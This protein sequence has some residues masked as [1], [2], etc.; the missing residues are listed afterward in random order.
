MKCPPNLPAEEA[1][2]QALA[3]HGLEDEQALPSLDPVV[4]IAARMFGM[5][6]SAVN[7]APSA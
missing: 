1:R 6:V 5:P 2:L 3:D 4:R 7:M